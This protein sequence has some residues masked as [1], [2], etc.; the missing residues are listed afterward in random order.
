[1]SEAT[2]GEAMV[3]SGETLVKV[4]HESMQAISR[5]HK[6]DLPQVRD[7]V[8][9]ELALSPDLAS[10]GF[11][12]KPTGSSTITGPSVHLARLVARNFGNCSVRSY[13]V[14]ETAE[15][16]YSL[17]GVFIDLE[18]NV[19]VER[20]LPV[21][22]LAWRRGDGSAAGR[23]EELV[24]EKL[25]QAL[26]VG[27]SKAERNVISAGVPDWL[28][29]QAFVRCKQLAAE[30]SRSQLGQMIEHCEKFGVRREQLEAAL[31]GPLNDKLT[32]D[33][34]VTL[35][36]FANGLVSGDVRAAEIGLKK[37]AEPEKTEAA[38]VNAIIAAGADVTSGIDKRSNGKAEKT[39]VPPAD[40]VTLETNG[41]GTQLSLVR[42][43][44]KTGADSAGE[45]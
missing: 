4:T 25:M 17:A 29:Q 35:K 38:D 26:L 30:N 19:V 45:F 33:Q 18:A 20:V 6:R 15:G 34:I 23:H 11:F 1:M 8:A 41:E 12:N 40:G 14:G 13:L 22:I 10:R 24:G 9:K 2:T 37:E 42:P 28:M 27:A 21:S 36:G 39:D 5:Q 31:G 43:P 32:D 7:A 3:R 16:I 44:A